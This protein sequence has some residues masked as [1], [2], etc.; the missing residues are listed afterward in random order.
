MRETVTITGGGRYCAD[1][2]EPEVTT[3]EA[4]LQTV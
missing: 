3:L 2:S 1:G 4:A